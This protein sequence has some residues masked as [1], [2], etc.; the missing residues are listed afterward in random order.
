[1]QNKPTYT[2]EEIKEKVTQVNDIESYKI[3]A[4][5]IDEEIDLYETEDLLT[6]ADAS[7]K[8]FIRSLLFGA[9]RLK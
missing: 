2:A 6:L 9:K 5:L 7:M 4:K 1:M 8:L 3:L